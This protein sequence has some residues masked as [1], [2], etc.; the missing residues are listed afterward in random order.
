MSLVAQYDTSP[1][2]TFQLLALLMERAGLFFAA[3]SFFIQ[4]APETHWTD[5]AGKIHSW[6]TAA[7]SFNMART[8]LAAAACGTW[9]TRGIVEQRSGFLLVLQGTSMLGYFCFASSL[10][11]LSSWLKARYG[12]SG[13][14]ASSV[15]LERSLSRGVELASFGTPS[16]ANSKVESQPLRKSDG[17]EASVRL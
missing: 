16:H 14:R 3:I 4:D 15:D 1:I 2:R 10:I 5:G 7:L 11:W 6:F 12:G 9:I 17:S 8:G 13:E